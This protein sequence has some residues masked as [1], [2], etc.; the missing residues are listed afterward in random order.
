MPNSNSFPLFT[1]FEDSCSLIYFY[2]LYMTFEEYK[3]RFSEI[4]PFLENGDHVRK[5]YEIKSLKTQKETIAFLGEAL[6]QSSILCGYVIQDL[7]VSSAD[8]IDTKDESQIKRM[9]LIA[10][11]LQGIHTARDLILIGSYIKAT[12]VI[13]QDYEIMVRLNAVLDKRDKPGKTPNPQNGPPSFKF[14][15]GHL[16]DIAHISKDD[17]LN[18][19]LILEEKKGKSGVSPV[20]KFDQSIAHQLFA[21]D[22]AIRFEI[23]RQ[24]LILHRELLGE[25]EEYTQALFH[26]TILMDGYRSEGLFE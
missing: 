21:Y 20:K 23:L 14:I 1:L 8:K 15:Y 18:K 13:K 26:Y 9:Q 24:Q 22:T 6:I 17:I 3:K 25:N 16:N 7:L 4:K 11:Y 5:L 19:M 12:A 10:A 2:Q